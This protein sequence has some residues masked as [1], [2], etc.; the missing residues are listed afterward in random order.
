MP[1]FEQDDAP[2]SLAVVVPNKNDARYLDR[3]IRSVIA[4]DVP[5]DEFIILD[6]ASTDDSV[7]VIEAAIAGCPF[8][9]LVRNPVNLGAGGVPNA[10]KGLGLA[11]SKFVY[12][13]GAND[14]VLPGFFR[15]VRDA[16]TRH[17]DAGLFSAM[18]WLCDEA[19]RYLHMHPSPVVAFE[20]R[21]FPPEDCRRMMCA[22][23]NWLT[24]Q[25]TVYRREALLAA[26]GFDASLRALCDLLAAHV[27]ASRGGALFAPV[28]LAVMRVHRGAFL[29][30]TLSDPAILE[31]ILAEV[32]RRGPQ[33]EPPLFTPRMLAR[34]RAR[35]DFA[36]LRLS[37]GRTIGH[38]AAR[39]GP[40]RR[41]ALAVVALVPR[42]M[43]RLRTA[44]YFA[45]T[46]PF[47]IL[48]TLRFRVYGAAVVR[49]RERRAGRVPPVG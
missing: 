15:R 27:V 13:L 5:P 6:D 10:N 45:V 48:P 2:F 14:Y 7:A 47:D 4:Q 8:A 34:T 38:I 16:F 18:V 3:C 26:G 9:R 39:S 29:V 35:F 28:P 41:A 36:S 32:S 20:D 21:F 43:R 37:E 11:R 49:R 17:P 42:A 19:G 44:L 23:G 33:V 30:D 31:S 12:F 24:G 46:R 1:P 22:L 40:V 25:T